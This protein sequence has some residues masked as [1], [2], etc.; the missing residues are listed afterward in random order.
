MATTFD[1]ATPSEHES[2][3]RAQHDGLDGLGERPGVVEGRGHLAEVE[4]ALVDPGL[5]DRRHD[6][7]H[8]RPDLARVLPVERHAAARTKTAVGQRRRASAHDI[9]EPI[10]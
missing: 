1:V 9:A 5:L 7:A 4:V 3:V 2:R 6:L 10:P 8:D